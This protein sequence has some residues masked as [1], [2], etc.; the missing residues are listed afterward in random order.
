MIVLGHKYFK[1]VDG[2]GRGMN[3]E[4]VLF[5]RGD[6]DELFDEQDCT[7]QEL[8]PFVYDKVPF[9]MPS[10]F[11]EVIIGCAAG[12]IWAATN[13]CEALLLMMQDEEEVTVDLQSSDAAQG[14]LV[15][16]AR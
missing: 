5:I 14:G 1:S 7:L 13:V 15:R 8:R 3:M 2:V 10:T 12:D 11:H 4:D 6:G 16:K 9:S